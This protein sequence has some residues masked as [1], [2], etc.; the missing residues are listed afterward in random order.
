M[1]KSVFPLYADPDISTSH[2][3]AVAEKKVRKFNC[4]HIAQNVMVES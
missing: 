2:F 1:T 3:E 4:K